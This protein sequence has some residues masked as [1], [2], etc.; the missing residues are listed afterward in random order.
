MPSSA[1]GAAW[2]RVPAP[3]A[4]LSPGDLTL[5]RLLDWHA[6]RGGDQPFVTAGDATRSAAGMRDE[7]ARWGAAF[8][9]APLQRGDRVAVMAGNRLETLAAI[10]GASWA[11]LIP[12]LVNTALRGNQLAHVLSDSGARLAVA[13][14]ERAPLLLTAEASPV[15]QLWTMD[16]PENLGPG[17]VPVPLGPEGAEAAPCRPADSF[18]ITYTSGTTGPAKGVLCPHA[19]FFWWG[20]NTGASIGLRPGDR[21]HTTLPLFHTNA[22]S[23]FVQALVFDGQ[24]GLAGR[25][26]ASGFWTEISRREATV[27]FLMGSMASIL[28]RRPPQEN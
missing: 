8:G 3:L 1:R 23:A 10:L 24:L 19:Q 28:M 12:V 21:L 22:L 25:F 13:D 15:E 18:L 20:V 2:Q 16:P 26:S 9:T 11:G 4:A 6:E 5:P 17:T 27:T 14:A 7:V